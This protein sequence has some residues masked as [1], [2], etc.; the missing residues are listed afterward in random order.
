MVWSMYQLQA[1]TGKKIENRN[2]YQL[3]YIDVK[4]TIQA[5][6][7]GCHPMTQHIFLQN[8]KIVRFLRNKFLSK[9][10]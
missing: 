1:G 6:K 3:K 2:W 10:V 8:I 4:K 7:Q 5:Q 9:F